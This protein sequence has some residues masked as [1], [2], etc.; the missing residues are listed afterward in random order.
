MVA[1]VFDPLSSFTNVP[2]QT[3]RSTAVTPLDHR[4]HKHTIYDLILDEHLSKISKRFSCYWASEQLRGR[5]ALT[6]LLDGSGEYTIVYEDNEGD[7]MLVGVVPWELV[8]LNQRAP[9][10]QEISMTKLKWICRKAINR[11]CCYRLR[12]RNQ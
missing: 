3:K 11:T 12:Q 7:R 10:L 9:T 5:P 6:G 8:F 1:V 4:I 2:S